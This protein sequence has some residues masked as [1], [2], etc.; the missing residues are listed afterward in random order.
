MEEKRVFEE[1][2]SENPWLTLKDKPYVYSGDRH[3]IDVFNSKLKDA[4]YRIELDVVPEPFIGSPDAP[5]WLLNLNPGLD[6][7]E[8]EHTAAVIEMQKRSAALQASEFWCL[9]AAF[10]HTAGY[11]WWTKRCRELIGG[12]GLKVIQTNLF[13]VEMFP[14]HSTRFKQP[15]W[16]PSQDFTIMLVKSA[17]KANK[18]FIVMRAE[19]EWLKRVPELEIAARTKLRIPVPPT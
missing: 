11:R 16:L 13:C 3:D 9:D 17:C 15:K 5:I 8:L 6:P 12:Y 14:Y 4:S 19:R 10:S 2:K 18:D 1:L 7:S